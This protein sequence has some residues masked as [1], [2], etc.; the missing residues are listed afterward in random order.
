MRV[1]RFVQTA[2]DFV[3]IRLPASFLARAQALRVERDRQYGGTRY[4]LTAERWIGDLGELALGVWFKR[5]RI[6]DVVWVAEDPA[7]KPDFFVRDWRVGVKSVGRRGA[8]RPTYT[9]CVNLQYLSEPSDDFFFC[10]WDASRQIMQL[11]GACERE[12]FAAEATR[13]A[14]GD[15]VHAHFRV[16]AAMANLPAT[17]LYRPRAWLAGVLRR[18]VPV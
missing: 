5:H 17:R 10:S 6:P 1:G 2:G 16:H 11:L 7:G 18:P 14:A 3:E 12:R 15:Q 8:F 4:Q 13:Y 9:V